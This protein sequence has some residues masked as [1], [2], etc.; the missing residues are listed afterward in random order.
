MSHYTFIVSENH[1]NIR[2]DKYLSEMIPSV[3]RSK[4][5]KLIEE[6]HLSVD[7]IIVTLN[8]F[9][10]LEGQSI[11]ITIPK[12]QEV[13]LEKSDIPLDIV[14]E[15]EYLA[16]INKPAG[17]SVHPGSGIS[18]G[19]IANALVAHFG[20][21]LANA[22]DP[23]RPGI[24]HRLDKDTSGLMLIAKTDESH[25]ILTEMLRERLIS[26]RYLALVKGVPLHL[27]GT[28]STFYG[29][30]KNDR[31]KMVVKRGGGKLAVTHFKVVE[32]YRDTLSL[33]EC[34]LETGRTHQ[35][36]VHL[37]YKKH[38]II[39]DPVYGTNVINLDTFDVDTQ[40]AVRG[41]KRQFLHAYQLEFEHPI[42]GEEVF[43]EANA[44]E[45]LNNILSLLSI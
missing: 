34:S 12:A 39:G 30:S 41:L 19:T 6:G 45:D 1:Q 7:G 37:A 17:I 2:A 35:I 15:D 40:S 38:P 24:V 28:I 42:T 21:N 43:L 14:Y 31:K 16:V 27:A 29:V 3:S 9:M 18:S 25:S 33:L 36:R 8:R 10:L 32:K 13:K 20:A 23:V 4:L 22:S 44:P 26:R 11:E 5:Q